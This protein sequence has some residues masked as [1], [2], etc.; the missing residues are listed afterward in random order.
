MA[1][2]KVL[3]VRGL[4]TQFHTQDGV[5]SAVDG[6]SFDVGAGEIVGLVGES[7]CGK[8]TA[9]LSMMRLIPKSGRIS[10]GEIVIDGQD[11]VPL[12]DSQMRRLRGPKVAMV[13]QDALTALD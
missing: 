4:K 8:S 11:I 9:A 2:A 1:T 7:G 5:V 10:A 12:S 6:L 3:D 13:F